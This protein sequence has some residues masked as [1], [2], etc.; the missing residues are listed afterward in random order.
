MNFTYRGQPYQISTST[1]SSPDS[2]Y[3]PKDKLI[4]RGQV[5]YTAPRSAVV[6]RAAKGDEPT[7]TL[8]YRGITYQRTLQSPQPYQQPHAVNWRYQFNKSSSF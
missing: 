5:Y 3:Q 6:S 2:V 1:Q 4:Y 8:T 7:V